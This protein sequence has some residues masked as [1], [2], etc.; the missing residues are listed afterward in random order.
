MESTIRLADPRI[1]HTR[2]CELHESELA[3]EIINSR[4]VEAHAK[5]TIYT[6]GAMA[7]AQDGDDE[8]SWYDWSWASRYFDL[9]GRKLGAQIAEK[10]LSCL[11]AEVLTQASTT[12][13]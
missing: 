7:V 11:S 5:K 13:F 2:N 8:V 10:T 12:A 4:G 1:A 3:V 6:L 9:D